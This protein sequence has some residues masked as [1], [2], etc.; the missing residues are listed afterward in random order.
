MRIRKDD[1]G[2]RVV[3]PGHGGVSA[4][5]SDADLWGGIERSAKR[6]RGAR[7]AGF[8]AFRRRSV[9]PGPTMREA[10]LN[11]SGISPICAR[12]WFL[13]LLRTL[14]TKEKAAQTMEC[15]CGL[16]TFL[17][18]TSLAEMVRDLLCDGAYRR[19]ALIPDGGLIL[20]ASHL[21]A[22]RLRYAK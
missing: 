22:W 18:R 6:E 7:R 5:R 10:R 9:G 11:A 3:A 1:T 16:R 19:W 13:L 2:H 15:L 17:N 20:D 12:L 21:P 4:A 14:Q 8:A